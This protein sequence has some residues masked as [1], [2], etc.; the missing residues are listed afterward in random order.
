MASILFAAMILLSSGFTQ[1]VVHQCSEDGLMLSSESCSMHEVA[2]DCCQKPQKAMSSKECCSDAYFFAVSPKFGSIATGK[3]Q[4]PHLWVS[5]GPQL[6]ISS[7]VQHM[8]HE[9]HHWDT[10]PPHAENRKILN[11]ICK[12]TI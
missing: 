11:Q 10:G 3:I 12:L 2:K 6:Q 8:V 1:F 4:F 7:N 9:F 5:S